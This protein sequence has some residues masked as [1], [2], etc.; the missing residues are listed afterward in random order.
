MLMTAMFADRYLALLAKQT[1]IES[2]FIKALPD[3]LNAEVTSGTVTTVDEASA[4]AP[5]LR[6]HQSVFDE[7]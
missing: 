2:S 4:L 3:H 5:S 7:G 1:P 6:S